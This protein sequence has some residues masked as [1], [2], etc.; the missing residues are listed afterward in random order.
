MG[1]ETIF[2][3][4]VQ[5]MGGHTAV[6]N[7]H[8]LKAE[9]HL[10]EPT[11]AVDGIYCATRDGRMRVD[12]FAEG[13]R[14]FSEG[15]DGKQGWQLPQGETASVPT[16]PAGTAALLNGIE[17]QL[18][19]LHELEARGHSVAL[20]GQRAVNNL[21]YFVI[22]LVYANG[23]T[24]QRYINPSNWLIERSREKKALHPDVDPTE[25]VIE[26]IFLDFRSVNGL[27][28]SFHETQTDL[29]TGQLL[30]TTQTNNLTINPDLPPT[31][32]DRP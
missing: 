15:L 14:V 3:N 32:F 23:T 10:I 1:L 8:S 12:I 9:F 25:A 4:H 20:I 24:L 13:V 16:S 26:T 6:T 17:N 27:L 18:F 7:L 29:S 31:Y 28:R 21:D 2:Q 11:F 19:G 30:Q 5:A 22:Q